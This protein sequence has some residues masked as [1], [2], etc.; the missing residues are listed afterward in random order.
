MQGLIGY[1]FVLATNCSSLPSKICFST[2]NMC[3]QQYLSNLFL[4]GK[5]DKETSPGLGE[6]ST[7]DV[8]WPS[9]RGQVTHNW[10]EL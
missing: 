4:S 5:R 8:C 2:K 9:D 10:Q 3:M 1:S 7:E 6:W